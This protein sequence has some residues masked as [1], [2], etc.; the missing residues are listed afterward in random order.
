MAKSRGR[1]L[2]LS[3]AGEPGAHNSITDFP[4]VEVGYRTRIEGQDPSARA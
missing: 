3:F 2:D 4:G 1:D